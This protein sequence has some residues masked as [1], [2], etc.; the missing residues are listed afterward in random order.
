MAI[1]R[2][3]FSSQANPETLNA[4]KTIARREGRQFQTVL[5]EAMREYVERKNSESPRENVLAH[6]RASIEKNKKLGEL[7]AQ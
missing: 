7:L 1:K 2:Q 5:E 3:K 6:V 4:L